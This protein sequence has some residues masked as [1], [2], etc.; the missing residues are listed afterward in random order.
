MLKPTEKVDDD[1]G[2]VAVP[3]ALLATE[4]VLIEEESG[5]VRRKD[6][7]VDDQQEYNPVPDGFKG[8]VVQDRPFMDTRRLQFVLGKHIGA[9]REDLHFHQIK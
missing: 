9:Q 8:R 5:D 2:I 6:G 3:L 4:I 1:D 7:R